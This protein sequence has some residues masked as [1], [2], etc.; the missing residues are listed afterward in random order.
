MRNNSRDCRVCISVLKK[1]RQSQPAPIYIACAFFFRFPGA[2]PEPE[3]ANALP[4]SQQGRRELYRRQQGGDGNVRTFGDF[5]EEARRIERDPLETL[6]A[7]DEQEQQQLQQQRQK[8]EEDDDWA[9]LC[10]SRLHTMNRALQEAE[11]YKEQAAKAQRTLDSMKKKEQKLLAERN[12][13]AELAARH[14]EAAAQAAAAAAAAQK[15]AATAAEKEAA[16]AAKAQRGLAAAEGVSR[17]GTSLLARSRTVSRASITPSEAKAD[18]PIV[19]NDTIQPS[20][21]AD[22]SFERVPPTRLNIGIPQQ[23]RRKGEILNNGEQLTAINRCQSH[24]LGLW[25]KVP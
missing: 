11:A 3:Y 22:D 13:L 8:R 16:A 12:E 10:M 1:R 19:R 17:K 20:H 14:K 15:E 5:V 9:R 4:L 21:K 25:N 24:L 23:G 6:L 2:Y 18:E 7:A